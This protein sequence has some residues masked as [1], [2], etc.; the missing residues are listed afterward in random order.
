M[1][2]QRRESSIS[3]EQPKEP[4]ICVASSGH[5]RE[6]NCDYDNVTFLFSEEENLKPQEFFNSFSGNRDYDLFVFITKD[7]D[8]TNKDS[9]KIVADK[10]SSKEYDEVAGIYSDISAKINNNIAVLKTFNCASK[11]L[12][13][14]NSVMNI[15][16]VVKSNAIPKFNPEVEIL[17]LYSGIIDLFSY[18][19]IVHLP[20]SIFCIDQ[21]TP[22]GKQMDKELEI[23][24][25]GK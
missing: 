10:L 2:E 7:Y 23:L 17:T 25:N 1:S 22:A 14:T 21:F 20:Y 11:K 15:P 12:L 9:L 3:T 19:L 24:R 4:R 16:F 18:V 8:F 5:K 13:S 6:L